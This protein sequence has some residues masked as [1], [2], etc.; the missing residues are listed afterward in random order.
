ASDPSACPNRFITAARRRCR[1]DTRN[2]RVGER[3]PLRTTRM[4]QGCRRGRRW[5]RSANGPDPPHMNET[6]Y[7]N[8]GAWILSYEL[9]LRGDRG[10][11]AAAA[12]RACQRF[13]GRLRPLVTLA[14]SQAFLSR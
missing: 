13:Y 5:R 12:E 2:K 4:R 6:A 8:I 11:V 3:C 1:P 10:T 14:G 9:A 7:D